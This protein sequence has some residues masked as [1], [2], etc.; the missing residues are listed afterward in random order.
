MVEADIARHMGETDRTE[1]ETERDKDRK[2][3][4]R[5]QTH[6]QRRPGF[7]TKTERQSHIRRER[8]IRRPGK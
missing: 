2:G 3:Q 1:I 6:R 4:T 8:Q 5:K 7:L